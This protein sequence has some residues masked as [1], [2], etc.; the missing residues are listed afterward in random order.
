MIN[1]K[2][3]KNNELPELEI[4]KNNMITNNISYT[5]FEFCYN[6]IHC[7]AIFILDKS[8]R[9]GNYDITFIKKSENNIDMFSFIVYKNSFKAFINIDELKNFFNI[10]SSTGYFSLQQ[11]IQ[12]F[13]KKIPQFPNISNTLTRTELAIAYNVPDSKKI[14]YEGLIK[15]SD[16]YRSKE[17]SQKIKVL[18]PELYEKIKDLKHI[19]VR[20]TTEPNSREQEQYNFDLDNNIFI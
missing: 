14:Y 10:K 18:M 16:Q 19:S 20:F 15:W 13:R 9:E 11:F 6:K 2:N 5:T 17:N 4:L 8:S 12:T 1:F 7:D 3:S